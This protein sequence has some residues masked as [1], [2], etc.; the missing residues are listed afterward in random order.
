M[1]H[2][3]AWPRSVDVSPRHNWRDLGKRLASPSPYRRPAP[4]HRLANHW[5][6]HHRFDRLANVP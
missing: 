2:Q 4:L 5:R 6:C 3:V 1:V